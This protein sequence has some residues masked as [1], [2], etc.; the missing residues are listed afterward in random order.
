MKRV[1]NY[2]IHVSHNML[3]ELHLSGKNV[4]KADKHILKEIYG[5]LDKYSNTQKIFEK[6]IDSEMI[7]YKDYF[8]KDNKFAWL[9]EPNFPKDDYQFYNINGL[10]TRQN[11]FNEQLTFIEK[12]TDGC[13]FPKNL[14]N[15]L[16]IEDRLIK[17]QQDVFHQSNIIVFPFNRTNTHQT[18][19]LE[20]SK[21][22]LNIFQP[23]NKGKSLK[24]TQIS[25]DDLE[26]NNSLNYHQG[27]VHLENISK[28]YGAH[29]ATT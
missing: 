25:L 13:W 5:N 18:R 19:F 2:K 15:K 6:N 14:I 4:E 10:P 29:R 26:T 11:R 22:G 21:D 8:Q 1:E 24:M 28:V 12:K 7:L 9:A 27:I 3:D 17:D 20:G 23:I 16:N